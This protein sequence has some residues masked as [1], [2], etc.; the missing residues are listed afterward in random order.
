M[1]EIWDLER[2]NDVLDAPG[3]RPPDQFFRSPGFARNLP[4]IN[5]AFFTIPPPVSVLLVNEGEP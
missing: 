5:S 4:G 1:M 2:A 3:G